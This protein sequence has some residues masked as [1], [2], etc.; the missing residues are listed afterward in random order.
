MAIGILVRD[1]S[2]VQHTLTDIVVRDGTNTSRTI[3]E[4]WV[5][6]GNNVPRLVFNPSGSA[7]IQVVIVPDSVDAFTAGTGIATTISVTATA[8]NGT[9]PYTYAWTLLDYTSP[10]APPNADFP[11]AAS[12]TFTQTSID[13]GTIVGG[14]FRVTATDAL[15]NTATADIITNFADTT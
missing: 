13:P 8:S 10:N 11:A 6:D 15:G 4:I 14:T 7:T 2:N 12:T 1:G 9:A 3:T 5:R